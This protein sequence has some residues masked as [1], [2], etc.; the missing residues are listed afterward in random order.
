MCIIYDISYNSD[1]NNDLSPVD[2]P[3]VPVPW[4]AG[5]GEPLYPNDGGGGDWL[6]AAAA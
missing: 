2:P 3:L 1:G 5:G 4:W 6:R